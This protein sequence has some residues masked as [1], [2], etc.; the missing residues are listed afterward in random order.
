M[1]RLIV[2]EGIDGSGKSTQYKLVCAALKNMGRRFTMLA[3]PRYSEPS[4]ALIKM[5][6]AGEFGADPDEVNPYAASTFYAVDRYASYIKDWK[7][8]YE[9]GDLIITDRY[10]TSNAVHQAS[11]LSGQHRID[12]FNWLADFEFELLK[13]PKPDK[14][15]FLDVPVEIAALQRSHRETETGTSG[16]IHEVHAAYLKR[17]A[18]CA[19]E[20]ADFYGWHRIDCAIDG[21][22]RAAEDIHNQIMSLIEEG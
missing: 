7:P 14:V 8:N 4:S 19:R 9:E 5:Y 13:L 16:D 6:L 15:I 18:E 20:A 17:C 12:Y 1:G 21:E 2:F 10:T 11:K 3:F 22:M